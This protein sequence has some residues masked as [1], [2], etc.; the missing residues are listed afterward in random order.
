MDR[1][2]KL[3]YLAIYGG[4]PPGHRGTSTLGRTGVL[5]PWVGRHV[6][7]EADHPQHARARARRVARV[8]HDP[9]GPGPAPPRLNGRGRLYTRSD[10]RS[11]RAGAHRSALWAAARRR[12]SCGQRHGPGSARR[13][14]PP[15]AAAAPRALGGAWHAVPFGLRRGSVA[16]AA[17]ATAGRIRTRRD[18]R[19]G[20]L[21]RAPLRRRQL[22]ARQVCARMHSAC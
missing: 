14:A 22:W 5:L 17:A 19:V 13:R 3:F 4:A 8:P 6:V 15:A 20:G 12:S 2:F 21:R 18:L 10:G 1:R 7:R 9:Q 16:V 11:A